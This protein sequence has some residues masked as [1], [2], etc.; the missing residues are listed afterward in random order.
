[1]KIVDV[2]TQSDV[3]IVRY[4]EVAFESDEKIKS[5]LE[6]FLQSGKKRLIFDLR[7]NPG[8]SLYETKNILNFFIGK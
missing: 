1:M 7:N 2:E 4:G 8:G 5:A 3:F 6:E